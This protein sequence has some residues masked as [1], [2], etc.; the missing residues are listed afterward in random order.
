VQGLYRKAICAQ[1]DALAINGLDS[2]AV[3]GGAAG[4]Y[5]VGKV[6]VQAKAQAEAKAGTLSAA[7]SPMAVSYLEQTGLLGPQVDTLPEPFI[8]DWWW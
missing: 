4:G 6:T 7:I 3:Q 5:T 1:V 2:I 8:T